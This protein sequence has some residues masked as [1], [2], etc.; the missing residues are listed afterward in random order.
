M[1]NT[2][3]MGGMGI[4]VPILM[5]YQGHHRLLFPS[6]RDRGLGGIHK[7]LVEKCVERY[8]S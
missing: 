3:Y 4:R 1:S 7:N 8:N 6:R 5:L 2:P